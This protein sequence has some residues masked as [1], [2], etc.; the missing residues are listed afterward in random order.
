MDTQSQITLRREV[1]TLDVRAA[2]AYAKVKR[3]IAVQNNSR[4]CRNDESSAAF[5]PQTRALFRAGS[6]LP[7]LKVLR[8]GESP[9]RKMLSETQA[10]PATTAKR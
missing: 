2:G 7:Q 1:F 9:C 10:R 3:S 5:R 6:G 8:R 4:V